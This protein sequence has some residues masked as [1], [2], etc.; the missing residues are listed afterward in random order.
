MHIDLNRQR[1][2]ITTAMDYAV[3]EAFRA[4]AD[5]LLEIYREDSIGLSV[6]L[7]FYSYLPE[8][9]EDWIREMRLVN[10][11]QGIFLLAV[12]THRNRYL[13]LVSSEG[14]EF[15]GSL[16]DGFLS[17][18]LIDYFGYENVEAFSAACAPFDRLPLY[19]PL[20]FDAET[21]PACHAA[22]GEYHELGCPVEICPWCGGQLINC[23]CRF[24]KMGLDALTT[25]AQLVEFE[26]L[27]E[28]RGRIPYSQ[29]QRPSFADEGPGVLFD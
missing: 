25:E 24:E 13:Y 26:I 1:K 5:D 8:A 10:R 11:H 22:T 4:D 17:E 15:Q 7:E 20:Q 19:E 28:E 6:L 2:A 16:D 12:R 18:E 29:E 3:P 9:Q 27:L 14:I 21:C 23:D